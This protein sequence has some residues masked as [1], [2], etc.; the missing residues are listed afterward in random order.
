MQLNVAEK[1]R[2]EDITVKFIKK[3]NDKEALVQVCDG[4]V[5]TVLIDKLESIQKTGWS[6]N[7][8]IYESEKKQ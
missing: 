5:I 3:V 8:A 2:Y 7:K 1:Y 4:V 6:R